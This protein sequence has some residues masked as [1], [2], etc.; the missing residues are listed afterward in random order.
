VAAD[1]EHITAILEALIANALAATGFGG[2]MTVAAQRGR[3]GDFMIS[4]SDTGAGMSVP[5]ANAALA[6]DTTPGGGLSRV[7]KMAGH[8]DAHMILHSRP[9]L[10]TVV[11]VSF[12]PAG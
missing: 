2:Q 11:T 9:G 4:V 8:H 1:A 3:N 10:G 7:R 6:G 5:E 12:S